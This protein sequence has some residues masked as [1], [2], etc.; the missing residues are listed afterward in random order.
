MV[1]RRKRAL[2]WAGDRAECAAGSSRS[3]VEAARLCIRAD[4]LMAFDLEVGVEEGG[5]AEGQ[6][7]HEGRTNSVLFQ[8]VCASRR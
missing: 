4:H 8:L 1:L 3:V 5:M 2:T 7:T 6:G